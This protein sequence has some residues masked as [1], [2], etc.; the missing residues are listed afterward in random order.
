[1]NYA[2]GGGGLSVAYWSHNWDK[3]K[4]RSNPGLGKR[5]V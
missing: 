3:Q 2:G 1:M 4:G 5:K